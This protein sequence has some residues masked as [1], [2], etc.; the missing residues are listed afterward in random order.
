MLAI[1]PELA[2]ILQPF[3]RLAQVA[4]GGEGLHLPDGDLIEPFQ[5]FALRQIHVDELGVH[6]LDVGQ[7]EQ[8]LNGG[9]F[10]HVVFQFWIGVAPL[11][12]GLSEQGHVEQVGLV[13]VRDGSLRRRDLG[14]NEMGF[15]R[16]GVN[17]VIEL[18]KGA[19]EVPGERKAAVFVVLEPLEFLDEVN[20]EFGAYPHAEFK[21]DVLVRIGAAIPA[22]AGFQA[23]RVG[24]F[25]PFLDVELVAVQA[26]LTFNCGEFARIKTGVVDGFP[27]AKKF[28]GGR[29]R[30]EK[31]QSRRNSKLEI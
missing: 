29:I 30:P 5:P 18:G 15:H 8:L 19:V 13:G 3:L 22:R 4:G 24:L 11:P 10:T 25:H 12:G 27:N 23:D 14:R 7:H 2:F 17:A 28:D 21:G 6:A 9:V 26:C 20:F 31:Y 16:V 1:Y